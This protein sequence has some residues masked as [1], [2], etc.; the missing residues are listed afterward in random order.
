M[1]KIIIIAPKGTEVKDAVKLLKIDGHEIEIEEPDP[2]TLLHILFG[3]FSPSAYGFGASYAISSASKED[4]ELEPEDKPEDEIVVPDDK[5]K[6][7]DDSTEE[8]VQDTTD[9]SSEASSEV[10]DDDFNFEGLEV[11]VDGELI[12][13][14]RILSEESE[15]HVPELIILERSNSKVISYNLNES[16]FSFWSETEIPMKRIQI[17]L[18]TTKEMNYGVIQDIKLVPDTKAELYIGTDL[19]HFFKS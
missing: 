11:Y 9:T 7:V 8:P 13:T 12:S 2:K 5:E 4:D 16:S 6:P 14:K 3:L 17:N 18:K 1:A 19:L 15:L 10:S